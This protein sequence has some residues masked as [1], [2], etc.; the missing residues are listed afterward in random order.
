MNSDHTEG[1]S[2]KVDEVEAVPPLE[3]VWGKGGAG[4]RAE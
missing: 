4:L 2:E 3:R 1:T